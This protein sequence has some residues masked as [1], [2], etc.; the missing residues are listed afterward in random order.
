MIDHD[1]A[2][3]PAGE[4]LRSSRR[5]KYLRNVM[6]FAAY[7][8]PPKFER[9]PHQ[10][11]YIVTPSVDGD[12][13]AM[14]EHNCASIYNTSIHEAYPGHHQQLAAAISTRA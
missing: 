9:G 7:F 10:G 2:T 14:R 12:A 13:G 8:S 3:M 1:I 6:P 4:T 5:P 11:I